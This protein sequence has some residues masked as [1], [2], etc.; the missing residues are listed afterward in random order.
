MNLYYAYWSITICKQLVKWPS[1]LVRH[2]GCDN[3]LQKGYIAANIATWNVRTLN[4][5]MDFKLQN[6]L[7]EMKRLKIE[8][9]GIAEINRI[10]EAA[11][12]IEY[13]DNVF[14]Y[15]HRNDDIHRQGVIN[16]LTEEISNHMQGYHLIN[17][18]I[19][20]IQLQIYAPVLSHSEDKKEEFYI[21]LQ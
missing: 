19:V 8:I 3:N 5:K 6:L 7:S 17:Q 21:T 2:W 15:F 11:E 10:N 9:L 1:A 4:G 13:N 18:W 16:I 12:V 20:M 14:I